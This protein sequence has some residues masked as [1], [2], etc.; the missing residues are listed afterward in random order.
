MFLLIICESSIFGQNKYN[1][2]EF[3]H[4]TVSFIK[5]PAHW[6]ARDWITLGVV[7]GGTFLIYQFD[8]KLREQELESYKLQPSY[9]GTILMKV[10][11]Q[12]GGFFFGPL[13]SVSLYAT[14]SL[15]N[16]TKTKKLGFEIAQAMIYSE[17]I[18]F[19]SKT[20][21]GRSRPFN[22]KGP[23]YFTPFALFKSPY[24][25]FPAGHTDAAMALSTV[26]AKNT[27]SY[28]LKVAAYVP[29]ALCL[30]QRVYSNNHWASD[31]FVGGALGYFVGN[32]VV[33]L[34]DQKD[35]RVQ[36][37]SLYPLGLTVSLNKKG[38]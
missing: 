30:F 4:E 10:G 37:T 31:V 13:L 7:G 15:A 33:N 21:I 5:T 27:D 16:S 22:G 32:W 14:G 26:L 6:D 3:G 8:A 34:H 36:V 2:S 18:S 11:E 35:S 19:T 17:V 29:A 24:N 1:L 38:Q 28:I 12:W 20:I 23:S 25:S 9:R